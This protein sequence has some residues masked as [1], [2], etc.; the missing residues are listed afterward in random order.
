MIGS[1]LYE[2]LLIPGFRRSIINFAYCLTWNFFKDDF[3]NLGRAWTHKVNVFFFEKFVRPTFFLIFTK[4]KQKGN[5]KGTRKEGVFSKVVERKKVK[6]KKGSLKKKEKKKGASER[7]E[8][9]G[10]VWG[11]LPPEILV[12]GGL[13]RISVRSLTVEITRMATSRLPFKCCVQLPAPLCQIF[14]LEP[15]NGT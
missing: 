2:H 3:K 6:V 8:R 1:Q 12:C 5:T 4:G 7:S 13:S 15:S 14:S 9:A 10:G 11:A